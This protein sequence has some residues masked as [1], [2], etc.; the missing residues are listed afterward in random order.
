VPPPPGPRP[1][2]PTLLSQALAA[3]TLDAVLDAPAFAEGLAPRPGGW[4]ARPPY[5]AQAERVLADPRRNLPH[6]PLVLHRRGF[7]DGA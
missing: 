4:R 1:P 5:L 3:F 6:H 7:P 2:L